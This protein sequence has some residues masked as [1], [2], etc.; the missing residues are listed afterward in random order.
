MMLYPYQEISIDNY[1]LTLKDNLKFRSKLLDYMRKDKDTAIEVCRRFKSDPVW[2]MN[3]FFWTFDNRNGKGEDR[4]HLPVDM[5]FILYDFQV[6]LVNELIRKILIEP[7][8]LLI[9]KSRDMGV[10]WVILATILWCWLCIDGFQALV[11]S[12]TELL[13]NNWMIDSHFGKLR[14]MLYK[15]PESLRPGGFIRKVHDTALNL[16]NPINGASVQGQATNPNF[17]RQGRYNIIYYDEFQAWDGDHQAWIAGGDSAPCRIVS[18]TPNGLSCEFSSIRFSNT[19][20]V[21][22]FHWSLH[23]SKSSGMYKDTK[24]KI[25]S[26][27][28]DAEEIRRNYDKLAIAQEL[29]LDYISSV[30]PVF[31]VDI[32][33]SR[34]KELRLTP[35]VIE[36]GK[37]L[38]VKP[39]K[40]NDNGVCI[41]KSDLAVE[42]EKD[43][44]G[45]IYIYEMPTELPCKDRYVIA[46]DVAEGLEQG[47]Y[48]VGVVG[49]RK[50]INEVKVVAEIRG[51]WSP[52]MYAWELIKLAVFYRYCPV[53]VEKNNMGH[54]VIEKLF[55][56]YPYIGHEKYQNVGALVEFSDKLG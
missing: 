47:D 38:W 14:Y 13:V 28:Y 15:L 8:D 33:N 11:G 6:D 24:G 22:S 43:E 48:D 42:F 25:R 9:D 54:A 51:H 7:N 41:N 32:I 34:I 45:D 37:L 31:D 29:D 2:A 56:V 1:P 20:A 3:A 52:H 17:G 12:R 30:R 49:D 10:T 21:K 40:F 50:K 27:W 19:T 26:P 16:Y 18:G 4:E 23:P 46:S 39:P 53:W 35:P 55:E 36:I 44:A 5:P